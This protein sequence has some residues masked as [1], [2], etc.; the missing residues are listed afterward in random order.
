MG[1]RVTSQDRQ[2]AHPARPPDT[3][4]PS[5]TTGAQQ[6]HL[7]SLRSSGSH[8]FVRHQG[9]FKDQLSGIRGAFLKGEYRRHEAVLCAQKRRRGRLKSGGVSVHQR[10]EGAQTTHTR[11]VLR[12]KPRPHRDQ[13]S[14]DRNCTVVIPHGNEVKS[15]LTRLRTSKRRS[16][17]QIDS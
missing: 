10:S 11:L 2:R 14:D 4:W 13:A 7:L 9:R 8:E 5:R 3:A 15:F 1:G 16:D 12:E 17:K 6:A